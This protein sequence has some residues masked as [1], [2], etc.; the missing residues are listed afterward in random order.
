MSALRARLSAVLLAACLLF[1][2]Q[3]LITPDRAAAADQGYLMLHF[4]GEGA[5]GQQ[6]YLAHSTD[7]LHWNDLNGGAPVLRS[8]IGTKGVR[9]PALVRSPGGDKYWIIA[10]DLCISCGQNWEAAVYN[11]SRDLVVWESTDLVTWSQPSASTGT[12]AARSSSPSEPSEPSE[13]VSP[14]SRRCLIRR[15]RRLAVPP[16]DI[17]SSLSGLAGVGREAIGVRDDEAA[18][19]IWAFDDERP[20]E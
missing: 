8:T 3:A 4:T 19:F 18:Q 10:T 12:Y 13:Q 1:T 6:M 15:K 16:H 5:A 17:G 20:V 2:S 7:G 11:G 14:V 9:D